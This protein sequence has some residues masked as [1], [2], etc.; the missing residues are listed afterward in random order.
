MLS[1]WEKTPD[2]ALPEMPEHECKVFER[3]PEVA[4]GYVGTAPEINSSVN[5]V[6]ILLPFPFRN[7]EEVIKPHL[8]LLVWHHTI[9]AFEYRSRQ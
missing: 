7:F 4:L 6:G 8:R 2:C 5:W 9:P 1:D 3:K